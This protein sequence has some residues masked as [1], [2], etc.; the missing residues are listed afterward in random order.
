MREPRTNLAERRKQLGL[1]QVELSRLAGVSLATLQNVEASRA[2]PSLDV[3]SRI[4]APL[5]LAVEYCPVAADWD[6]LCTL[7]LP[8]APQR[9]VDVRATAPLLWHQ[10][11]RAALELAAATDSAGV[12]R[13]ADA[14]GAVLY[15]LKSHFPT[16]YRQH[17]QKST[18]LSALLPG[19]LDG[20]LISLARIATRQLSEYI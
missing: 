14:V 5:G 16:F 6:L 7:G 20:R 19:K 2:N 9:D 15:A 1:T 4:L 10:L 3:M 18:L 13:K 11:R 12:H 8:L 17:L